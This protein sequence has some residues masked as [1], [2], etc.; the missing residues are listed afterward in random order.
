MSN[1]VLDVSISI[2]GFVAQTNDDPGRLNDWI[3]KGTDGDGAS[4]VNRQVLDDARSPDALGAVV[5]GRRIFEVG[6][7]PWG[8]EPPFHCPVFVVTHRAHETLTKADTTFTF[9]TDGLESALRQ[10][11]SVAGDSIVMIMGANTARQYLELGSID[12]IQLHVIPIV[13]G[14]GVRLID[15]LGSHVELEQTR[16]IDCP[17]VTHIYYRV[18]K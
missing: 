16:L 6:Q 11:K 1:V 18:V 9:V 15:H 8:P 13:F 3:F 4:D 12:V 7:E 2:D 10:A 17:G 14:E 5:M